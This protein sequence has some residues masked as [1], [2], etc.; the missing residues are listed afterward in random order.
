V[1]PVLVYAAGFGTR[2]RPLTDERPKPLLWIG[3]RPQVGHILM[4]L[5]HFGVTRAVLN[6]HHLAS[7]FEG[8]DLGAP[9]VTVEL[10]R[11]EPILGTA[12]GLSRAGELLGPGPALV[13][14]GD[15]MAPIDVGELVGALRGPDEDRVGAVLVVAGSYPPGQGTVGLDER[16]Q[17]ARLRSYR[18]T[19]EVS[20]ADYVGV[21]IVSS[22][23]RARLPD[24]G[25]LVGD[26]F[27]PWLEA[28]GV[29]GT[30][31]HEGGWRDTGDLEAYLEAN[32]AWLAERGLS[33]HRGP[34]ARIAPTVTLSAT[35][36][37][38]GARVE[39]RG[40][41][42]SCVVWPGVRALA[43]LSRAVVTPSRVV[44]VP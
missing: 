15:I 13:W 29:L 34:A 37:G 25:C 38:A 36:V 11:E 7:L 42:E 20:G 1:V 30:R 31:R 8:A 24:E 21:A 40:A 39:G 17:V 32:L 3:D 23:L 35:V 4:H 18:R 28:G 9:A 12:G 19:G 2:L 43:P 6:T 14:N 27:L 44:V 10:S 41:L 26:A 33:E 16:G 5:A 22:T